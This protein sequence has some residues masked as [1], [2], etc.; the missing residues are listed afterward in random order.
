MANIKRVRITAFLPQLSSARADQQSEG[1]GGA[2]GVAIKRAIDALLKNPHV[3]GKRLQVIKLT[4]A[5]LE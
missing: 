3:K 1:T 5:V 2:L 4:I